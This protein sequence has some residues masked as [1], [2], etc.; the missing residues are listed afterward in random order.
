MT[1]PAFD[2]ARMLVNAR[3]RARLLTSLAALVAVAGL[4]GC[5][6]SSNTTSSGI[7]VA[8]AQIQAPSSI[9]ASK[10]LIVCSDEVEPP[11]AY[12]NGEELTGSEVEIMNAVGKLMG[13]HT[14]YSQIGF[15]G[16]FAALHAG[17]CNAAIDEISDTPE[18]EHVIADVDYME[19][20]QTFMVKSGNPEHLQSFE[21]L[22]GRSVGAVLASVDLEYLH[23]LSKECASK[24][25]PTVTIDGFNDDPTGAEALITGKIDAFEED[26]PLL[27]GLIAR[28]GGQIVLSPQAQ[29]KRIPCGI[30]VANGNTALAD[31]IEKAL[32][33]LYANGEMQNVFSKFHEGGVALNGSEPVTVDAATHGA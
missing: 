5:G 6:G 27:T 17:K 4:L 8:A 32:N 22:C 21:S 3:G 29:I 16:L 24:G 1:K 26:T 12:R 30:A 11:F 13:V 18:R 19:V 23:V 31:A 25:K 33:M 20:G 10:H 9:A 28:S 7:S 14:E 15:D 2:G